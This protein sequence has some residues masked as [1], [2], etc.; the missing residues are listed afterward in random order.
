MVESLA[1]QLDLPPIDQVGFV[2]RDLEAAMTLYA[3]LFG[4]FTTMDGS[5]ER[6]LFRDVPGDVSLKLAFGRSG[7]LEIELIE[8]VTGDSPHSEFILA[9]NE[10]MHHIRFRVAD[11]DEVIARANRIGFSVCW[12]KCISEEIKFAYMEREG[13]PLIIEF[14]QMPVA[15]TRQ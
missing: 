7:N 8:W 10:G 5:V 4:P 3:P 15:S 9:G 1:G 13:D 2:V 14:L 12:Y 6:A 11:C